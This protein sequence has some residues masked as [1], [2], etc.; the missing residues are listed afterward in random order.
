M[1]H[2][3]SVVHKAVVTRDEENDTLL[4]EFEHHVS[5]LRHEI[6]RG[7]EHLGTEWRCAVQDTFEQQAEIGVDEPGVYWVTLH[8]EEI[9]GFD[10]V[11]YDSRLIVVEQW[12]LEDRSPV[13]VTTDGI[14]VWVC[15]NNGNTIGRF[16]RMGIDVHS[17]DSTRCLYCTHEPTISKDW[18]VFVVQMR[19]HHGVNIEPHYRPDRF[20][21]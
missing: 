21:D 14:T 2:P 20:N 6:W 7:D 18:D 13:Q 19:K 11:E 12:E 17:A 8:S 16:G 1:A 15:D 9:R 4:V 5:C 10:W 3:D